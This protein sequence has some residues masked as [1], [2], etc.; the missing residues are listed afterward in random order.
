MIGAKLNVLLWTTATM[1]EEGVWQ[2]NAPEKLRDEILALNV[3]DPATG[4]GHFLVDVTAYIAEWLRSLALRPVDLSDDDDE[5]QYWKR[6]VVSACIYGVDRNPLAV[7]L[8]KLSLWLATLSRGKPLSF[9]DPHIRWGDSLIGGRGEVI[10][11]FDEQRRQNG[12]AKRQRKKQNGTN[13]VGQLP[14][15]SEGD[16]APAVS[17]AI[18]QMSGIEHTVVERVGQVKVQEEMYAAL[19]EN[20]STWR[21]IANVW[22]AQRFGVSFEKSAWDTLEKYLRGELVNVPP[23]LKKLVEQSQHIADDFAF[24]HW[25]LVFPE[26]FFQPDGKVK[27]NPGFDAVVG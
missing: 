27:T 13:E 8:A 1:N 16:F 2:V 22:L 25:E 20:L 4:S 23:A 26:I 6:Q 24:F 5:L 3:L 12:N 21:Q 15:F 17:F 19:T 11:V 18:E 14:I 9:L 7:E 10:G